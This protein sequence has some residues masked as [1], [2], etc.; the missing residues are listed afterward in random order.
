MD[1]KRG[2]RPHIAAGVYDPERVQ[3]CAQGLLLREHGFDTDAGVIYYVASRE[4]VRVPFDDDL[5]ELTMS[6]INA[7]RG[8]A[9]A[10]AHITAAARQPKMPALLADGH[11]PAR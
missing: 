2:S 10:A 3:L 11:L 4:R 5:I 8:I 7:L 6:S 1:Y 9:L